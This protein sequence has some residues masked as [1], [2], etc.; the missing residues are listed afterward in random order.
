MNKS[1]LEF[2]GVYKEYKDAET[3]VAPLKGISL[4]LEK[5]SLNLINGHSG[6]G[7]TT[8]FNLITLL[9]TPTAGN[10]FL[11]DLMVSDFSYSDRIN[12]RREK[13][14]SILSWGN[15]MPYLNVLENVMLPMIIKDR[16]NALEIIDVVGLA[17]KVGKF[18]DDLSSYEKQKTALARAMIN[19]PVIIVANEPFSDLDDE[20]TFKF[21]ELLNK[22][23]YKTSVL[24]LS[25]NNDL[26]QYFDYS[27]NLKNGKIR[28]DII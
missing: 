20:N 10:I 27:F 26:K 16:K 4:K 3:K 12:L 5:N 2:K 9:D 21:M 1:I 19:D 24:V 17:D 28:K 18:P 14:G 15:L 23:K 13:I 8:I 11:E 7:K 22:I 25:D 6:S